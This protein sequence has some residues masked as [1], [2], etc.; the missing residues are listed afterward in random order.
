MDGKLSTFVDKLYHTCCCCPSWGRPLQ[1][2]EST[3]A[4]I[5]PRKSPALSRRRVIKGYGGASNR[6]LCR[7]EIVKVQ[8]QYDSYYT[9]GDSSSSDG[10]DSISAGNM[11]PRSPVKTIHLSP[12]KAQTMP[13]NLS[14]SSECLYPRSRSPS[15]CYPTDASLEIPSL[16]I[17][18]RKRSAESFRMEDLG[19]L[20]PELYMTEETCTPERTKTGKKIEEVIEEYYGNVWFAVRF[21]RKESRLYIHLSKITDLPPRSQ[22]APT[23]DTFVNL[24]L[25]PDEK[26]SFNSRTAKNNLNPP[27]EEVFTFNVDRSRGFENYTLRLSAYNSDLPQWYNAIGHTLVPLSNC[28]TP[29][30]KPQDFKRKLSRKAKLSEDL[31]RIMISL[32]YL[33]SLD[34]LSV[35]ILRVQ[36]IPLQKGLSEEY[37]ETYV[38]VRLVCGSEKIKTERTPSIKGTVNP[39]FAES[40]SYV[41]PAFFIERTVLVIQLMQKGHLRR[42]KLLGQ[43]ILG[44]YILTDTRN[45]SHF[46]QMLSGREAV[47]KWHSLY[48]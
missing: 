40:L 6:S 18:Q 41:I 19:Q 47:R 15:E 4:I 28:V 39:V 33:P 11:T 23:Y 35:V 14:R 13:R 17:P 20:R 1:H 22:R 29:D 5:P 30:E 44:P 34:R 42:D 12:V 31:G 27:F 26:H 9:D 45:L 48:L 16:H 32:A 37:I 24:C 2:S 36:D 8:P 7:S 3:T 25:L 43:V 38:K 21:D 10:S 46:G